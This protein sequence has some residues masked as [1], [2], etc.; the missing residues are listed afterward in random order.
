MCQEYEKLQAR[1][2]QLE[3]LLVEHGGINRTSSSDRWH[4]WC[5]TASSDTQWSTVPSAV[6][7]RH[8][9]GD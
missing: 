9:M 3:R 2:E 1:I 8:T 5:W 7:Q 4:H 6:E